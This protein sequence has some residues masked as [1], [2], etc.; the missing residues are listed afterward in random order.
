MSGLYSEFVQYL[1][2]IKILDGQINL[3]KN[4]KIQDK[5]QILFPK[6]KNKLILHNNAKGTNLTFITFFIIL[7]KF[8]E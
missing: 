7:I 3:D 2:S 8:A 1:F 4:K 5:S 6:K